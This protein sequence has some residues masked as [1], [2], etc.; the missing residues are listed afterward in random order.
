MWYLMSKRGILNLT[1][2]CNK[3]WT[4]PVPIELFNCN[5]KYCASPTRLPIYI[6]GE[7]G[8]LWTTTLY[9]FVRK[10]LVIKY[11]KFEPVCSKTFGKYVGLLIRKVETMIQK[12][13]P[14]SFSWALMVGLMDKR[15]MCAFLQFIRIQQTPNRLQ[16]LYWAFRLC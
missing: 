15:I 4:Q 8:Q 16:L 14:G 13:L 6:L 10:L 5:L 11:S 3:L 9:L 12:E 1:S 2:V 7:N